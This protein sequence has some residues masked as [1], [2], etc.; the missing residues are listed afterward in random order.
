MRGLSLSLSPGAQ[1]EPV[2]QMTAGGLSA[3]HNWNE[4]EG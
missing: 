1:R 3:W 2:V 4:K